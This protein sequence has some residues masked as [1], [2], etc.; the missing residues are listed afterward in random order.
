MR[1]GGFVLRAWRAVGVGGVGGC[2][3]VDWL[4]G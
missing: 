4:M 1:V 3:G 2:D